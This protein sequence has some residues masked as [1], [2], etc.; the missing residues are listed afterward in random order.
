MFLWIF[1]ERV[2]GSENKDNR[3]CLVHKFF[4]QILDKI[5]LGPLKNLRHFGTLEHWKRSKI[6]LK[7]FYIEALKYKNGSKFFTRTNPTYST[8]LQGSHYNIDISGIY[9]TY[10]LTAIT[11]KTPKF[12][13]VG[14]TAITPDS[15]KIGWRNDRYNTI[16]SKNCPVL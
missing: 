8:I 16:R 12:D 5:E 6:E 10:I 14:M 15:F 1:L 11:P 2:K 7:S 4:T 9:N 3:L 13:I